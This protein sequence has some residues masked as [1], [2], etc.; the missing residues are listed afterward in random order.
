MSLPRCRTSCAP[1]RTSGR[2]R[3]SSY[4]RSI[5]WIKVPLV[6]PLSFAVASITER[7]SRMAARLAFA[8]IRQRYAS[9]AAAAI[10]AGT[11][12]NNFTGT[13]R[14]GF[15]V[16]S[17]FFFR[18][19]QA[20]GSSVPGNPAATAMLSAWQPSQRKQP[21]TRRR[22]GNCCTETAP[23]IGVMWAVAPQFQH[24]VAVIR[25]SIRPSRDF[26]TLR[27]CSGA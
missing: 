25:G 1:S 6:M 23:A 3:R 10:S 11:S 21:I 15:G 16:H 12:G 4:S 18:V 17:L 2:I 5:F 9:L 7:A 24:V 26:L 27:S 19:S 8:I 14:A 13:T 22:S 20:S